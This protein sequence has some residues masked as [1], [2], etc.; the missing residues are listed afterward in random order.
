MAHAWCLNIDPDMRF[1]NGEFKQK[2]R[3]FPEFDQAR[4]WLD[5]N[6]TVFFAKQSGC[7]VWPLFR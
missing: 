2:E 6:K 4:K 5:E 1:H 7:R 3:L